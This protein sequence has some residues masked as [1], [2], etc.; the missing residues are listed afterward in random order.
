MRGPLFI[1]IDRVTP[2]PNRCN[3]NN[4]NYSR[5]YTTLY[6]KDLTLCENKL[7]GLGLTHI[8]SIGP[9]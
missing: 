7:D 5:K 1:F 3:M 6:R 9:L 4:F 8:D 2:V